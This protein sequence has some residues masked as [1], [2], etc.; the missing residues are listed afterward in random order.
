MSYS[1]TGK[2]IESL[3]IEIGNNI[4]IDI[5]NWHLFLKEAKLHVSLSER[6]Y[7]LLKD[8]TFDDKTV[9]KVLNQLSVKLGGGKREVP[10]ADLIPSACVD[11]LMGILEEFQRDM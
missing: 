3:A 11:D 9:Q 10:L 5:A 4:Y 1:T 7:P 8:D 2:A 6:L